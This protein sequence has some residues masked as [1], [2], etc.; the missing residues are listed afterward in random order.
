MT[1]SSP[2][3]DRP[4]RP[5]IAP[6]ASGEGPRSAGGGS[7]PEAAGRRFGFGPDFLTELFRFPLDPGYADAATR[8]DQ[9]GPRTGWSS[10]V[11]RT[12][13]TVTAVAIGVLL[14]VAY[15]QTVAQEPERSRARAG[16]VSQIND[17]EQATDVL[18]RRAEQLREQVTRQ[19]DAAIAGGEAARLR[20]LEAATGLA[21]VRGD[22]VVVTVD[23]A[24][25]AVDA[26][27]GA[28][29]G[30]DLG[31]VFDQD[32]QRITNALWA[33]GAEAVAINGQ[34]LTATTTIRSAGRAILVD[35]RPVTGP[36]QVSAIGPDN[37]GRR[38]AGSTTAT[39]I[40]ELVSSY[41][42][43]YQL[44]EADDLT[45][46]AAGEPRL[47]YARPATDP[48]A[49]GSAS[50]PSNDPSGDPPSAGTGP[51]TSSPG[52]GP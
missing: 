48:S 1:P 51:S 28:G 44:R 47:R 6:P 38:F 10:G 29:N 22:G 42:I 45:L 52:G 34:R 41:G 49:S 5:T 4:P 40:T 14:A 7:G 43:S 19:R 11:V 32:L 8:R 25:T 50:V 31:R 30:Q 23:D 3:P 36:Y 17:R 13:S 39:F 46:P 12:V 9:V 18:Q 33:A 35:F 27:T 24:P 20:A 2:G 16:L 26:V 37:L 21:R 15:R